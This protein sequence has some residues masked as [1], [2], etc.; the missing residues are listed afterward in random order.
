MLRLV[1][2][3]RVRDGLSKIHQ[4]ADLYASVL[5]SGATL[6]HHVAMGNPIWVQV[7][8]G[9]AELNGERLSDGE[10][11]AVADVDSLQFR[12]VKDAECLVIELARQA[13]ASMQAHTL[14][15]SSDICVNSR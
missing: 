15:W 14:K 5:D 12:A 9:R 2:S 8:S 10:G 1:A 3:D 6:S 4:A 11:A 13:K 7:V